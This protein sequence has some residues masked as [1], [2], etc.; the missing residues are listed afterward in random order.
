MKQYKI[1]RRKRFRLT[2]AQEFVALVIVFLIVGGCVKCAE[3][4]DY[5]AQE[6]IVIT[7][8]FGK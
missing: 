3:A 2:A 5:E 4:C 8:V 1:N 6:E 7:V